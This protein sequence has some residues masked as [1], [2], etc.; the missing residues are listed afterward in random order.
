M[1]HFDIN[2]PDEAMRPVLQDKID[3]L[4]KPKGSMGRLEE[5]ALQIGLIQQTT[6]PAFHHPCHLLF[7]A[8]HGVE[9]ENVSISPR[10]ITW[11]QM[12][13][14]TQGGAGINMFCRQHGFELFIVDM[15]VDYDLLPYP[16]IINRKIAP[17]TKNFRYEA[18]MTTDEMNRCIDTGARMV[19]ECHDKGCNVVSIGEMGI[20]NTSPSS[21]WMHLLTGTP[22]ERCV[23]AGAGL[24]NEGIRHK[25][26]VLRDAVDNFR[27]AHP[28]Y[29]NEKMPEDY[30]EEVLRWFGGF[31]MVAAVGAMLRAAELRMTVLVDGFIMTACMLI[32]SR[33][34]PSV[35]PYA[36]FCHEG[37]ESGHK[38]M[39]E[40]MQARGLLQL[41][42]RLGEGTGAVC[43]YPILQS[44]LRMIG[45]MNNFE[46][47]NITKY[48]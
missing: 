1:R 45:E 17:G 35:L 28:Q 9:R 25:Y 43:A 8:D 40:A 5:L 14:F 15:G 11:Q 41:D 19:T 3:N 32:A 12:L 47:A 16:D 37:N 46:N 22:L 30:V 21:V 27:K 34:N 44:A 23:G 33:L 4:N 39:L 2:T 7:G 38:L 24:D 13:N 36:V 42:L 48:F 31:E 6:E 29:D 26:E 10:E 20:A 18:A